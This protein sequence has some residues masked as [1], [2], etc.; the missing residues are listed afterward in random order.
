MIIIHHCAPCH[1]IKIWL[2]LTGLGGCVETIVC[3]FL[4]FFLWLDK[5]TERTQALESRGRCVV[6]L[7]TTLSLS[8]SFSLSLSLSVFSSNL[9]LITMTLFWSTSQSYHLI[10]CV[11]CGA[12]FGGDNP[13]RENMTYGWR[14]T[15]TKSKKKKGR[16]YPQ[17]RAEMKTCTGHDIN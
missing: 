7:Y 15:A 16:A 12:S 3:Y 4:F 10:L 2:D 6:S 8:Y 9:L 13:T 17:A 14:S 5:Q 11:S 1:K